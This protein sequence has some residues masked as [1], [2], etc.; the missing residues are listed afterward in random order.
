MVV[1]EHSMGAQVQAQVQD[2]DCIVM[3]VAGNF[4]KCTL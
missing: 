2:I 4:S 1:N 3:R